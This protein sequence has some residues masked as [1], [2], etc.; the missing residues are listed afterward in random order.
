M[1]TSYIVL[2]LIIIVFIGYFVYKYYFTKSSSPPK[3]T[4][5]PPSIQKHIPITYSQAVSI[6][7]MSLANIPTLTDGEIKEIINLSLPSVQQYNNLMQKQNYS[8]TKSQDLF[9][10]YSTKYLQQYNIQLYTTNNGITAQTTP[11]STKHIFTTSQVLSILNLPVANIPTLTDGEF[12]QII[13]LSLPSVQQ[14]NNL[15][16]KQTYPITKSQDLFNYYSTRYLQQNNV[17]LYTTNNGITAQTTPPSTKHIFTA[18]QVLSILNLPVANIPTL[19]DGEFKQI[20]NLSL[21]SV[22]QYNNLMQK[23]TYPITKSQEVFNYYA[24]K[25]LQQNKVQLYTPNNGITA[26]TTPIKQKHI[27]TA[28]QALSILNM[29]VANIPILTDGEFKQ[30]INL[31]LPSVQ[32]YNNLMQKQTYPTFK[33]QEVFNYYS[34]IYSQQ[35]NVQLYTT[36]HGITAQTTPN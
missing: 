32:Q 21:P 28:T 36:N 26:Q 14:Y 8:I 27:I 10:Y 7:N 15:M 19:T 13:N 25:Y 12:K 31:S 1:D 34:T 35:N 22:Q 6:L 3:P 17:Q 9:N 30:I 4:Y 11:P 24:T 29:P 33:S 2:S 18:S 5:I 16:Q 23:Q 20:I